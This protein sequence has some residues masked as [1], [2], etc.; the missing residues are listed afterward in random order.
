MDGSCYVPCLEIHQERGERVESGNRA[1]IAHLWTLNSLSIGRA[2]VST[3][4]CA[5]ETTQTWRAR[6]AM[7]AR[8][9][10][11]IVTMMG[12]LA[13]VFLLPDIGL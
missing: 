10:M 11:R 7:P 3:G 1:I 6:H 12:R 8:I 13:A 5:V 9:S 4:T 2:V